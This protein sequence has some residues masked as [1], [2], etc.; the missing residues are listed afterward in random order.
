[1]NCIIIDD[2][3][4]AR[5]ILSQLCSGISDLKVVGEFDSVLQGISFLKQQQKQI[6]FILLDIHLPDFTG[7]DFINTLA[8]GELKHVLEKTPKIILTTSDKN[9]A[10]EAYEYDCVV[11]YLLKPILPLRFNKAIQKIKKNMHQAS[12]TSL[13]SNLIETSENQLFVN[14][15]K[16]LIKIDIPSIYLIEAK[17]DYINLKTEKNNYIVHSSLKKIKNKLPDALFLRVHRSY[18]INTNKILGIED[19]TVLIN[20]EVIPISRSSR[21]ELMKRINLL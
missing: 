3:A 7:F 2:E 18:I 6:D 21:T 14:I 10:I 9:F 20:K 4:T 19:N 11:D 1:M 5:T 8:S 15:D 16:R 12:E 13:A 17:G